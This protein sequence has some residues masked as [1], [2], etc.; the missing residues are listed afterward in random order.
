MQDVPPVRRV[1]KPYADDVLRV[2]VAAQPIV[3][4]SGEGR[5][6]A[7]LE[8][9]RT[10][11]LSGLPITKHEVMV[12]EEV[13]GVDENQWNGV[14]PR[15]SGHQPPGD[16]A[17]HGAGDNDGP[18]DA[19]EAHVAVLVALVCLGIARSRPQQLAVDEAVLDSSQVGVAHDRHGVLHVEAVAGLGP[20]AH[21]DDSVHDGRDG[22]REVPVLEPLGTHGQQQG[23]GDGCHEDIDGD[24]GVVEEA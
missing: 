13:V 6:E 14:V 16:N 7:T 10:K 3:M 15:E 5:V 19:E 24:G 12:D 1:P 20:H 2:L 18:D 8:D 11:A 22:K 21:D 23:A 4:A 9:P 17:D